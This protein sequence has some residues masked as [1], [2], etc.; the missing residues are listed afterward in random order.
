MCPFS[1]SPDNH[2]LE[3][4]CCFPMVYFMTG[5]ID[6]YVWYN[7]SSFDE[8]LLILVVNMLP[9]TRLGHKWL[10]IIY[11]STGLTWDDIIR[12][13]VNISVIPC[14]QLGQPPAVWH[15]LRRQ[16]GG[17]GQREHNERRGG[18]HGRRQ[19]H[20]QCPDYVQVHSPT[21]H[22]VSVEAGPDSAAVKCACRN[23]DEIVENTFSICS[24]SLNETHSSLS[25]VFL[26]SQGVYYLRWPP[27]FRLFPSLSII[28]ELTHPSNMRFMQFRAKDCYSLALSKL[29]KVRSLE[30]KWLWTHSWV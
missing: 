13:Y 9:C 27:S 20:C 21:H 19:D 11:S 22:E 16:F 14:F 5:T 28:T 10:R 1:H 29:E 4:I 3:A 2:F 24:S 18:L 23:T 6:K 15:N 7:T 25:A 30:R 12:S 8:V 17:R 26:S